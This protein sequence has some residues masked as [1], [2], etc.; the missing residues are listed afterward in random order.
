MKDRHWLAPAVLLIDHRVNQANHVSRHFA[1]RGE[2]L[3]PFL[4]EVA[5]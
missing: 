5:P 1:D 3:P 2:E 4:D